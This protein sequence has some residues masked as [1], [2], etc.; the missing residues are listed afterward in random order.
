MTR[1]WRVFISAVTA[2]PG[3]RRRRIEVDK[4]INMDNN[5]DIFIN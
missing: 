1:F 3:M 4:D 2:M 5:I